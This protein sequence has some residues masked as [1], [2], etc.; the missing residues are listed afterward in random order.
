M[1]NCFCNLNRVDLGFSILGKI[2]KLG[3]ESDTTTFNTLIKGLCVTSTVKFFDEIVEKGFQLDFFTYITILNGLC[4]T[5]N[6]SAAIILLRKMEEI[7]GCELGIVDYNMVIDSLCKERLVTRAFKLFLEMIE[8]QTFNILVDALCKGGMVKEGQDV[9]ELMI[10]RGEVPDVFTYNALMDGYCQLGQ[11]D[12]SR[13]VFDVMVNRGCAPSLFSYNIL[14][15]GFSHEVRELY[16]NLS[17]KGLK[18]D[19]RSHNIMINGL[20]KEGL[21]D[22]ANELLGKMEENGCLPDLY[23]YNI[24]V[25]KFLQNNE[26]LKAF[27][28]FHIMVDRGILANASTSRRC[29]VIHGVELATDSGHVK[30]SS[31][32]LHGG[33][34]MRPSLYQSEQP[35]G[36][37]I[38]DAIRLGFIQS[39]R[40]LFITS[41]LWCSD[42]HPHHVLPALQ[43]SLNSKPGKYEFPVNKQEL[44]PMDFKSVWEAM[45]ECQNL[46]LK[47]FIGV[48]NFSCKKLQL[49]LATAKIPAAVNQVSLHYKKMGLKRRNYLRRYTCRR[50]K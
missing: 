26:T 35:L 21:P 39:R 30:E 16:L 45:E 32:Q 29:I 1:I 40:D 50:K 47:K 34:A 3:Y 20:C 4:K 22:E 23:L 31:S 36:E 27:Q 9:V 7:G 28:L 24:V 48:S 17:A 6:A 15:N 38:V 25:Q 13:K 19:V 12:E 41:K 14:I 42:A 37:S 18:P 49:L 10:Q 46:G 11:V 44:L 5:G 8:L 33:E 43:N 2:L